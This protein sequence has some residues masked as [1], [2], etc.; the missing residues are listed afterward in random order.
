[1]KVRSHKMLYLT[2]NVVEQKGTALIT[3]SLLNDFAV[4]FDKYIRWQVPP[5]GMK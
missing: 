4:F 2:S 5:F 1:M 3:I